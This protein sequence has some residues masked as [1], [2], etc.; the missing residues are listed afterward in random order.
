MPGKK[1]NT[2]RKKN[3]TARKK[4]TTRKSTPKKKKSLASRV[5]KAA[6]TLKRKI[7]RKKTNTKKVTQ[8]PKRKRSTAKKTSA[9]KRRRKSNAAMKGSTKKALTLGLI[10]LGGIAATAVV[11][12]NLQPKTRAEDWKKYLPGAI[13]ILLGIGATMTKA[14]RKP[15][16]L[17]LAGTMI[18]VGA[19]Q[20]IPVIPG[21]DKLGESIGLSGM[22][23]ELGYDDV[24][25]SD[26]N[27]VALLGDE[28]MD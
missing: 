8:M 15:M 21:L 19:S 18:G 23:Q 7:T 14:G 17:A 6:S 4:T 12:K 10:T 25:F 16:G 20:L 26:P 3:T 27:Q 22:V 11:K 2:T 5:K 1:K 13:P 28:I 9:P 24:D